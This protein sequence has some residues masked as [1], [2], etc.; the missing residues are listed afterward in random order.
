MT[1]AAATR[2]VVMR[3]SLVAG[4]AVTARSGTIDSAVRAAVVARNMRRGRAAQRAVG[5]LEG[6]DREANR[7]IDSACEATRAWLAEDDDPAE[8]RRPKRRR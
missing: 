5:A 6:D 1:M 8:E 3:V 4:E 7:R 2:W